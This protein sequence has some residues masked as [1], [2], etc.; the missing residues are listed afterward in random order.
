MIYVDLK[1]AESL[2]P[3]LLLEVVLGS[4]FCLKFK[5][6]NLYQ[7]VCEMA[8]REKSVI[9]ELLTFTVTLPCFVGQTS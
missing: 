5:W 9:E 6:T 8:F 1:Q 2:K 4:F 3:L 7:T